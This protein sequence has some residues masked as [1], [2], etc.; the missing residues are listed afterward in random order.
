MSVL[1]ERDL[2]TFD[3]YA[4]IAFPIFAPREETLPR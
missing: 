1:Q 3:L 2:A 4:D